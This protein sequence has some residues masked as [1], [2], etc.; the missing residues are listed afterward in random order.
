MYSWVRTLRE[1]VLLRRRVEERKVAGWSAMEAH[2]VV[3]QHLIAIGEASIRV[4]RRRSF[5]GGGGYG[6]GDYG[7]GIWKGD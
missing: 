6:S 5:C 2:R 1:S 7:G 4:I 3:N